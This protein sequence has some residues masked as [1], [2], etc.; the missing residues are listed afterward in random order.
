MSSFDRLILSISIIAV[1]LFA[2][3]LARV[4]QDGGH[5][6]G[7]NL[8]KIRM[9]LQT[10]AIYILMPVSASLS[11]WGLP[12]P[13]LELLYLPI[14]GL[15]AY[16]WGGGLAIFTAKFL[17]MSSR[18]TGSFFCCG[19]FTNI[20]AVGAL[21]CLLFLGENSI[22]LVALYRLLEEIYYFSIVFPIAKWFG[23]AK[24]GEKLCFRTFRPDSPLFIIICALLLGITLNLIHVPR[25]VAAGVVASGALITATV[26]FLFAIGLTLRFTR[27]GRDLLP[28][29]WMTAIK[30]LGIPALIVPAAI[31]LDMGAI[32]N[33]LPLKTV[34]VLCSMPVAMTAL[35]PP[36]L[37]NLDTD[38]A[39]TC[40]VISTVCLVIWLPFL[41]L[42][43]PGI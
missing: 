4:Y 21:V 5:L 33:G 10:I 25:P 39:N 27:I 14:L 17:R 32:E 36:A 12:R 37:F 29:I 3:W 34:T 24:S 13:K 43:L 41:M 8:K 2:G 7:W 38:L 15:M 35:I 30:Y 20:G 23:Q 26:F 40:W 22:A 18:Q 6:H 19:S 1:S 9:W 16:I 31:F 11:L 28:G 42:I